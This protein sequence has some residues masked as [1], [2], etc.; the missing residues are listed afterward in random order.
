MVIQD[1]LNNSLPPYDLWGYNSNSSVVINFPNNYLYYLAKEMIDI[2]DQM[3]TST[4]N[5]KIINS[6]NLQN[7]THSG[8]IDT[9]SI[10]SGTISGYGRYGQYN[11]GKVYIPLIVLKP[12]QGNTIPDAVSS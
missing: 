10:F 12:Q 7:P 2:A 5:S 11:V 6:Y 9:Y 8:I 1:S 4:N 3:I